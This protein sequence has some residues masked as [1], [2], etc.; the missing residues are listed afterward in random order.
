METEIDLREKVEI[1]Y[2]NAVAEG[3][4]AVMGMMTKT[5]L[6]MMRINIG[7]FPPKSS[8]LLKLYYYQSLD[9]DDLSYCLRVPMTYVPRYMGNIAGYINSGIQY[10]GQKGEDQEMEE[11]QKQKNE[12]AVMEHLNQPA[13]NESPYLWDINI[14]AKMQGK[15]SHLASK[16]HS[17][18]VQLSE[19]KKSALI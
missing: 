17:I 8:A 4:T 9:Y 3:K 18:E 2:E 14:S 19:D 16:F 10:K 11:E 12:E 1:K 7:N 5:Q 6:D 15:I 13:V